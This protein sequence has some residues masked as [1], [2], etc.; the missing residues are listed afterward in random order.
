[1]TPL[2]E[3]ATAWPACRVPMPHNLNRWPQVALE[4]HEGAAYLRRLCPPEPLEGSE[5]QGNELLSPEFY[6]WELHDLDLGDPQ[7]IADFVTEFGPLTSRKMGGKFRGPVT[8]FSMQRELNCEAAGLPADE[9]LPLEEFRFAAG[10]LRDATR[11]ILASA[12]ASTAEEMVAA[13]ETKRPFE[14]GRDGALDQ[15]TVWAI[16]V[17]NAGLIPFAPRLALSEAREDP[18]PADTSVAELYNVVCLEIFNDVASGS[19]FRTCDRCKRVFVR[20]RGR[21]AYGQHKRDAHLRYCSKRCANAAA[22]AAHRVKVAKSKG[23]ESA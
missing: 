19:T 7:A 17:I 21:A 3:G 5:S 23:R 13:W 2:V 18:E 6:L 16:D 8:V 12:G 9:V 10:T 22:Q 14:P 4:D 15:A 20:Q 11:S 1:M